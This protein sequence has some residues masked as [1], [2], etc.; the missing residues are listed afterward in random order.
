MARIRTTT[1][2]MEKNFCGRCGIILSKRLDIFDRWGERIFTSNHLSG[3]EEYC[4]HTQQDIKGW[5]GTLDKSE[6]IAQL[7]VYLY[8]INLEDVFGM[9]HQ[10]VGQVTLIR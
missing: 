8:L 6:K 10:Y 2:T 4:S 7:G 3:N 1:Y 5:D 9:P